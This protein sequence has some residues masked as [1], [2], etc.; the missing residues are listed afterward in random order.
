MIRAIT[1]YHGNGIPLKRGLL[2]ISPR[3]QICDHPREV[4][5]VPEDDLSIEDDLCTKDTQISRTREISWEPPQEQQPAF[6]PN[7][8]KN[9][10]KTQKTQFFKKLKKSVIGNKILSGEKKSGKECR[11]RYPLRGTKSTDNI[12]VWRISKTIEEHL[13]YPFSK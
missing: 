11:P 4:Y 12:K 3:Q 10:T 1:H 2:V 8:I 5:V 13:I 7:Y 6:L 9:L